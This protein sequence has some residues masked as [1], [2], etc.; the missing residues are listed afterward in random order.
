LIIYFLTGLIT[1]NT[2][3]HLKLF[4]LFIPNEAAPGSFFFGIPKKFFTGK[5]HSGLFTF[6]F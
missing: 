2:V 6:T 1:V 5:P 3:Y 4:L